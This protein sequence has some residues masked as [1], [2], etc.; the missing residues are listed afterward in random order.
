VKYILLFAA[1]LFLLAALSAFDTKLRI[2]RHTVKSHKLKG[3]PVKIMVI[4]DMHMRADR[5]IYDA[6]IAEKPHII[7]LCGDVL[8]ERQISD[9]KYEKIIALLR[10]IAKAAPVYSVCGN[11]DLRAECCEKYINDIQK[12]GIVTLENR[13]EYCSKNHNEFCI[14]G[15][16]DPMT[17]SRDKS[18][19]ADESVFV[20]NDEDYKVLLY[21]RATFSDK[22]S[23]TFKPD[24]LLT[25]HV[26]GGQ[27][28]FPFGRGILSPERS[29]FPKYESGMYR[30]GETQ[31]CVCRGSG[32]APFLPRIFNPP[33]YI[34]MELQEKLP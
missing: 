25:G 6:V 33:E 22:I 31:I 26:H 29:F 30:E 15:I 13:A 10:D 7:A 12:I 24:L 27:W 19:S 8:D 14:S 1:V 11:H 18:F 28:R 3:S 2:R 20:G 21:H 23:A 17:R 16:S 34:V 4:S 5:Q 32:S 9:K